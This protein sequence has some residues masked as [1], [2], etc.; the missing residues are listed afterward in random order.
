V[1]RDG[2]AQAILVYNVLRGRG[3]G[4]PLLSGEFGA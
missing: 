3:G 1:E 2:L 4:P